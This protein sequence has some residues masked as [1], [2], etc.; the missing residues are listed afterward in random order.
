MAFPIGPMGFKIGIF[1]LCSAKV[2]TERVRT[3]KVSASAV[4]FRLE[5]RVIGHTGV[6]DDPLG[7]RAN[8]GTARAANRCVIPFTVQVLE[9][10]ASVVDDVSIFQGPHELFARVVRSDCCGCHG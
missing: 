3:E 10:S 9:D 1:G 2:F 4:T 8:I 7:A 5:V 6:V